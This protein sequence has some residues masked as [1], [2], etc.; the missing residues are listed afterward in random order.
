MFRGIKRFALYLLGFLYPVF[1]ILLTVLFLF[2]IIK[3]AIDA[4]RINSSMTKIV[5]F[6]GGFLVFMCT[7]L[8][9]GIFFKFD[10]PVGHKIDKNLAPH[11]FS[12]LYQIKR[13]IHGKKIHK[14]IIDNQLNA[15]IEEVPRLGVFWG[16]RRTLVIG[17]PL[18]LALNEKDLGAVLAH[19]YAHFSKKHGK[20]RAR[21]FRSHKMWKKIYESYKEKGERNFLISRFAFWYLPKVEDILF[22]T[23][24]REEL[25]ADALAA[26][27]SG[28]QTCA[29]ALIKMKIYEVKLQRFYAELNHIAGHSPEPVQNF[30]SMMEA[31]FKASLPDDVINAILES[32][33]KHMALPFHT[34]PSTSERIE[35]IK[36]A[37][38]VPDETEHPAY[39]TLIVTLDIMNNL[40]GMY[41]KNISE[42]WQQR[43]QK[44]QEDINIR[45]TLDKALED[46]TLDNNGTLSRGLLIERYDGTSEALSAFEAGMKTYPDFLPLEYHYNRLLL[47]T[48]GELAEE[49]LT[50]LMSE[51][52]QLIP[53]VCRE[54]MNYHLLHQNKEKAL[55]YYYYAIRFMETNEEAKKERSSLSQVLKPHDLSDATLLK[56]MESIKKYRQIKK[57]YVAISDLKLTDDF[58]LYCIGINYKC[59]RKKAL[60]I[61]Q[62]IADQSIIGWEAFYIPINRNRE[63]ELKFIALHNSRIR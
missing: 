45:H 38:R 37:I 12:L 56:L 26:R 46:G 31:S 55:Q 5:I 39:S 44:L 30:F 15:Y 13:K 41:V 61:Q 32:L 63:L 3:Y 57:V 21:I 50:Q 27:I 42:S 17:L 35:A 22:S 47:N 62:E 51:D 16:Y 24:K 52:A 53:P 2:S 11:L 54:L 40:N 9:K 34:H 23:Q 1:L 43:Y 14:V 10:E 18:L 36:A 29:D 25:E 33:R 19:E 20:W 58:P 7:N 28:N 8:L 60:K 6:L 59:S 49:A 48:N 4:K